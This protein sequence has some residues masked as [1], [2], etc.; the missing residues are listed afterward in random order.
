MAR[1]TDNGMLLALGAVGLTAAAGVLA[2]RGSRALSPSSERTPFD[3]RAVKE[4]VSSAHTK[5]WGRAPSAETL[6]DAVKLPADTHRAEDFGPNAVGV[7]FTEYGNL[8][9]YGND[10]F[11]RH[12]RTQLNTIG[13]YYEWHDGGTATIWRA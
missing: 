5:A 12:L 2:R 13:L 7:I 9:Q 11:W 8:S 10:A 1:L 3:L 4:A 6:R